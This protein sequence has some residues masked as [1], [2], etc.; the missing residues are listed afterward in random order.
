MDH[1]SV[2][3]VLKKYTYIIVHHYYIIFHT[4]SPESHKFFQTWYSSFVRGTKIFKF[5]AKKWKHSLESLLSNLIHACVYSNL[6]HHTLYT[7][8]KYI[9][10]EFFFY[11]SFVLPL[12][13]AT[14]LV[15]WH[16]AVNKHNVPSLNMRMSKCDLRT[17]GRFSPNDG[18]LDRKTIIMMCR[19]TLTFRC[20]FF[21]L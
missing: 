14:C 11:S 10:F 17:I 2:Y 16:F 6:A 13:A 5:Q 9:L 3:R 18:H 8:E 20:S 1:R 15:L 4:I 19:H 21:F 7:F 12:P